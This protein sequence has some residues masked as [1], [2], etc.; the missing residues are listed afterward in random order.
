MRDSGRFLIGEEYEKLLGQREGL[1]D[2]VEKLVRSRGEA[3]LWV[4]SLIIGVIGAMQSSE[5]VEED[6]VRNY[7]KDLAE[8]IRSLTV[9]NRGG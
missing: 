7:A 1:I 3:T 8:R 2:H 4:D 5:N 9:P 6:E